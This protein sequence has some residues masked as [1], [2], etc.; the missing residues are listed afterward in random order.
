MEDHKLK[1]FC[2]VAET[3]SFSKTSEIIHVTQPAVSL[4]IQAL[5]EIYETKL[6]DRSSSFIT[7]T[8]AGEI[9]YQYAKEILSLYAQVEK[10]I[11][12]I[13][14]L[15]KGSIKIGAGT[16]IGNYLLPQAI[17]DF[18]KKHPKIKINV[19]IGNT[20]VIT[21]LVNL[22]VIDFG[23]VGEVTSRQKIKVEPFISDELIILVP[24]HHPWAKKKTV[25]ILEITKEPFILREEGSGTRQI[26]EKYLAS[27]GI[28][29]IDMHIPLI[30]GSTESIK[31]A[32]ESG[33]GISIVSKWAA[34]REA[35]CGS[36]RFLTPK[37]G[38]IVRD[39][40]LIR[41]KNAV[42]SPAVDEF[43]AYLKSYSF[44][45]LLAEAKI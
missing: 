3:K 29:P 16:T 44:D 18:K 2:T 5:E 30:F 8:Q 6:F 15:I 12:K 11:G 22:G 9:L 34:R 17:F 31:G 32:V 20:K 1:V 35:K 7:L 42:L 13:T 38:R 37:E 24:L 26:V 40:S 27:H 21:D 36:L 41:C 10:D 23:F 25:S 33:M 39:F 19:T 43:L 4:Q 14:G 45:V 28:N